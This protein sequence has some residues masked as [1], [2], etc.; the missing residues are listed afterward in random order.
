MSRLGDV[1]LLFLRSEV[2][3]TATE[4]FADRLGQRSKEIARDTVNVGATGNLKASID[5][6]VSQFGAGAGPVERWALSVTADTPYAIFQELEPGE[7]F[8]SGTPVYSG[9]TRRQ[10]GGKPYLRPGVFGVTGV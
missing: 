3:F 6:N 10:S 7:V 5:Y 1:K 2:F 9:G 8:P 4:G